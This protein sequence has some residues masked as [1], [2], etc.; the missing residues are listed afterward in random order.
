MQTKG[1]KP[2]STIIAFR[3]LVATLCCVSTS[4]CMD[5]DSRSQEPGFPYPSEMF[6][7]ES[8]LRVYG[9]PSTPFGVV[10]AVATDMLGQ[11]YVLDG[12]AQTVHVFD[13]HGEYLNSLGRR[14]SGPG[15]F[16]GAID[17]AVSADSLIWVTDG[18]AG[19]HIVFDLDGNVVRTVLR[20]YRGATLLGDR[21]FDVDG[22]YVDWMLRFPNETAFSPS[23][24]IEA[25]PVVVG[26]GAEADTMPPVRFWPDFIDLPGGRQ[27]AVFFSPTLLIAMDGHGTIWF[28]DSRDYRVGKRSLA[29]DTI[30]ELRLRE[31]AALVSDDDRNQ[32]RDL[33]HGRASMLQH[34]DV[35]PDR[36]P[37]IVG[38]FPDGA[39]RVL[40]VPETAT[41]RRGEVVDLFWETGEYLGRLLL[42]DPVDLIPGRV[43]MHATGEFLYVGGTDKTGTPVL[44]RFRI[45]ASKGAG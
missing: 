36:K 24:V 35:L 25:Y 13:A 38:I 14:G 3:I 10:A 29:G 23:D 19:K 15:E 32:L 2:V 8:D 30:G 34:I 18:M 40:V 37:I 11:F 16:Q 45:M 42:P 12:L 41:A 21:P 33:A 6:H 20:G 39:G 9:T 27:P 22:N 5:A 7:L 17:I 31:E 43:A 1:R 28:S 26:A 44:L 4:A